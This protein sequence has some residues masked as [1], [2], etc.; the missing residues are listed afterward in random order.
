MLDG[1]LDA[2]LASREALPTLIKALLRLMR[3]CQVCGQNKGYSGDRKQG[4]P[5]QEETERQKLLLSL[6]GIP[7]SRGDREAEATLISTRDPPIK[8]RQRGRSYSYLYQG[9]PH[10]EETE[11]QNPKA[12][13]KIL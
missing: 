4:S 8:R 10:Q 12:R 11:R 2:D 6:P 1:D 3:W 13:T 7:P 5:H 9:S